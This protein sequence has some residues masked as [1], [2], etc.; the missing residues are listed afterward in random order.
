M[1]CWAIG[2]IFFRSWRLTRD[3]FFAYFGAA[4]WLLALHW[5]ALAVVGAVDETRHLFYI[6]RLLGF[7]VVLLAIADKNRSRS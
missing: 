3:R 1:G 4:F 6:V 5:L 7:V 2:L